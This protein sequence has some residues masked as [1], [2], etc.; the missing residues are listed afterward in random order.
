MTNIFQLAH[1]AG[2]V[3]VGE[4]GQGAVRNAFGLNAQL[5]G[6]NLQ[7]VARQ[8]GHVFLALTQGRQAQADDIEAVKQVL[9]ESAVLDALLQV[10]VGGRNYAHVGF[11]RTMTAYAVKVAVA[12]HAQQAGLQIERHVANFIEEQG[13]AVGL[14][15]TP[16]AHRLRA[17]ES[18]A[19]VPEQLGLEQVFGDGRGV[20]GHKRPTGTWRMLVQRAR[21]QLFARTRLTRDHD[22]DVALAQAANGTKHVLHGRGLAQHLGRVGHALFGHLLALAFFHRTANQLHRLGQVK[23]LGQVLKGAALKGRYG[24]VQI[25]VGRHDDDGQTREFLF[26]FFQQ[27]QARTARHA[28]VADQH[29]RRILVIGRGQGREDIAWIGEAAGRQVFSQ[30]CFLQHEADGLVIIYD[31]NRLHEWCYLRSMV[32]SVLHP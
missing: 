16:P 15:K 22:G 20:D 17:S 23:G 24:A 29:Q 26:N 2:E 7:E 25:R 32:S 13:A 10:L 14:F 19:L 9:A 30:Q 3:E 12:Q 1:I 28:N 4:P 21:H 27:L 18:A 5:V 31:P 11:H 8:H 6:A